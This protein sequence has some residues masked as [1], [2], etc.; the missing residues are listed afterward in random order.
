VSSK[1]QFKSYFNIH[2]D[3][4]NYMANRALNIMSLQDNYYIPIVLPLMQTILHIYCIKFFID[5]D[6]NKMIAVTELVKHLPLSL[7][8]IVQSKY[9]NVIIYELLIVHTA[10]YL[11]LK[12][13]N[14]KKWNLVI[15]RLLDQ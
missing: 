8:T 14:F 4:I 13:Y 9:V 5:Q 12:N 6:V 11:K 7:T 1:T 10:F 3:I 2:M 15:N